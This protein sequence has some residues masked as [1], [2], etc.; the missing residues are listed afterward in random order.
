MTCF[1]GAHS[2]PHSSPLKSQFNWLKKL[3]VIDSQ[4]ESLI[5]LLRYTINAVEWVKNY[6]MKKR[7][8]ENLR[9]RSLTG[10]TLS[11]WPIQQE[12]E[13]LKR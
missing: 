2:Y 10:T 13:R 8:G 6:L 5:K 12:G 4:R 9:T 1:P 11:S 3:S 7:R